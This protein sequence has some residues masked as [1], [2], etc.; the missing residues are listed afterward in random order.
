VQG[1]KAIKQTDLEPRAVYIA[2]PSFEEL[3]R[4][5]RGRGTESEEAVAQRLSNAR[6]EIEYLS[7]PG[8][9]DHI[10]VNNDLDTA[11]AELVRKIYEWYPHLKTG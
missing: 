5:L 10:V 8:A 6:G 1:L 2:P 11:F 3:E 4:R 9:V 7:K